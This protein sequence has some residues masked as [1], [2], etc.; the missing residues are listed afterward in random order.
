MR[1]YGGKSLCTTLVRRRFIKMGNQVSV[2][3]A[4]SATS[5]KEADIDISPEPDLH[6]TVPIQKEHDND[7]CEQKKERSSGGSP[8]H[9]AEDEDEE[10]EH[11]E[12]GQTVE[13]KHEDIDTETAE[14]AEIGAAQ[15]DTIKDNDHKVIDL[16]KSLSIRRSSSRRKSLDTILMTKFLS[17]NATLGQKLKRKPRLRLLLVFVVSMGA[18]AVGCFYGSLYIKDAMQEKRK[19]SR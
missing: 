16:D 10:E 5:K 13:E 15:M 18:C 11:R 9:I 19:V 17:I 6:V 14:I 3:S 8:C 12:L 7:S 4:D 2:E 1:I